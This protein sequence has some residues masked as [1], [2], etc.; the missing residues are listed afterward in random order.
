MTKWVLL[1]LVLFFVTSF[2][3]GCAPSPS[4]IQTAI[5]E[6]Q[7]SLPVSTPSIL[8][9][10]VV[11]LETQVPTP[12]PPVSNSIYLGT[13]NEKKA[14][15]VTSDRA[16]ADYEYYFSSYPYLG[17][18]YFSGRSAFDFNFKDLADPQLVFSIPENIDQ[19]KVA[20]EGGLFYISGI[21]QIAD[22]GNPADS[23][24]ICTL[25]PETG[26]YKE[27]FYAQPGYI[28]EIWYDYLV[29]KLWPCYR[30]SGSERSETT[31]LLNGI[32]GAFKKLGE[33]GDISFNWANNSVWYRQLTPIEVPCNPGEGCDGFYTDYEPS[34]EYFSEPL[35]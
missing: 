32:T 34:G 28:D 15:F 3:V 17:K 6:T 33:V 29:I 24:Y 22:P 25:D 8:P 27:V 5:V 18:L 11:P 7:I 9:A 31:V 19:I 23:L 16:R 26:E 4:S 20:E 2:E 13:V 14:I 30:C 1:M 12:D 10:A 21:M 35:P